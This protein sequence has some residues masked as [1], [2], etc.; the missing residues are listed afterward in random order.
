MQYIV[1]WSG[2]IPDEVTWYLKRSAKGWQFVLIA[3]TLGQFV[4]P[5][6]A[7]LSERVRADRRWLA[8]LCGLT[9]TMRCCEAGILILPAIPDIAPIMTSVMLMAALVFMAAALWLAFDAALARGGRWVTISAWR[10]RA[11]TESK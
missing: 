2:N 6:F 9:L 3:L 5:F 8:A 10:F 11:E 7:L 1:I 4:F